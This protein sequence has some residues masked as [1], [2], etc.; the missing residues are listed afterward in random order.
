[1]IDPFVMTVVVLPAT[2]FVLML[3]FVSKQYKRCPSNK[4]LVVF[5]KV[6][7]DKA[8]K[9]VHGG[10]VLVIPL[11]QDFEYMSLEPMR[12]ILN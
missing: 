5:G 7:G 8:S 4:I 11:I 6:S 2:I 9:C 12:L 1:M 10:G 3:I